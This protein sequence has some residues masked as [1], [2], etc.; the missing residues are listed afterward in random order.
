MKKVRLIAVLLILIGAAF[1]V[2]K[3]HLSEKGPQR[4]VLYG[5]VDQRQVD[6][7]FLDAERVAEVLVQEGMTVSPGQIVARL[8]T[9]RLRDRIAIV[10]AR[11]ESANVALNRLKNG[12]RPEEI[13]QARAAVASAKAGARVWN[14]SSLDDRLEFAA[15]WR[16]AS[17]SSSTS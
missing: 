6:L 3:Y 4:L 1:F 12:T 15:R 16:A 2:Q 14:R 10:E 17:R 8:E 9:R 13:D 7:A 5:N 11:L